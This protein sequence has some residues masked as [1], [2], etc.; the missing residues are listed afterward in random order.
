VIHTSA[1]ILQH[2]KVYVNGKSDSDGETQPTAQSESV[3]E[4][5]DPL[6]IVTPDVKVE[7][8]VSCLCC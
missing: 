3:K 8:E 6:L 5:E 1:R 7:D 2:V 4:E